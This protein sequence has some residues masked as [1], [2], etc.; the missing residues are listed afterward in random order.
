MTNN[1]DKNWL[2]LS[3]ADAF[4]SIQSSL[5]IW[6]IPPAL[7]SLICFSASRLLKAMSLVCYTRFREILR[8]VFPISFKSWLIKSLSE[9]CKALLSVVTVLL[10]YYV[11]LKWTGVVSWTWF[12]SFGLS[13]KYR[14]KTLFDWSFRSKHFSANF[15]LKFWKH[16]FTFMIS[17][18]RA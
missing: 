12:C 13:L 17:H 4:L 11:T 7:T 10:N 15:N 9:I 1:W 5:Y 8:W 3:M 18:T 14:I 16:E 6:H 2:F